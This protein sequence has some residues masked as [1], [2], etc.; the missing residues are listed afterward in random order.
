MG[1][2]ITGVTMAIGVELQQVPDSQE[3][4]FWQI[5][6]KGPVLVFLSDYIR[7]CP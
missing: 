2:N 3:N 6:G 7:L 1:M 5:L 4:T